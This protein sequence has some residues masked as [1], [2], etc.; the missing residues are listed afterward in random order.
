MTEDIAF[1]K[2]EN[3]YAF[4]F[5][6]FSLGLH[7][8]SVELGFSQTEVVS[9]IIRCRYPKIWIIFNFLGRAKSIVYYIFQK[10]GS[11]SLQYASFF[12]LIFKEV[13]LHI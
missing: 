7:Q 4:Q 1:G 5:R 2:N 11:N 3:L 6:T 8:L 13:F 12:R 9:M 10:V